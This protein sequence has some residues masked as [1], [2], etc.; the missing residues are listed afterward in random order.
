M[1]G[2]K[3]KD[4]NGVKQSQDGLIEGTFCSSTYKRSPVSESSAAPQTLA[5]PI[6]L[7]W[8]HHAGLL[9]FSGVIEA[10]GR[11][12][13]GDGELMRQLLGQLLVGAVNIEQS[14]L[15][16]HEDLSLLLGPSVSKDLGTQRRRLSHAATEANAVALLRF[17]GQLIGLEGQKDFYLDP[18]S[19]H[20]SGEK[21]IL[22]GWCPG[23]G[24]AD[25][26]LHSDFIHTATGEP[27]Y[28]QTTDNYQDL[29]ERVFTL[30]E[31]FRQHIYPHPNQSLTFVIDRAIFSAQT[32]E[33]FIEQSHLHLIS[34]EK[35]YQPGDWQEGLPADGQF[36]IQKTRNHRADIRTYHFA[37]QEQRWKN[38]P[39]MRRLLVRATNPKNKTVEVSVLTDDLERPAEEVITLIFNR[40]LQENDF[41]Y[42]DK[43]FGIDEIT[44]YKSVAYV[45]LAEQLETK[46]IK[47]A[48]YKALEKQRRQTTT[49][50]KTLLLK[51][52]QGKRR[53][54]HHEQELQRQQAAAQRSPSELSAPAAQVQK[55]ILANRQGQIKRLQSNL[56]RWD[57]QI[58]EQ[59]EQLEQIQSKLEQTEKET[60]RLKELIAQGAVKLQGS[61]K[62]LMDILKI[63]ARNAFYQALE[64]FRSAYDNL[65]DDHVL[66]R[67][68]THSSGLIEADPHSVR[69]SVLAQPDYAPY[70]RKLFEDYFAQLNQSEPLMPDGSN[71]RL[72]LFLTDKTGFELV[73]KTG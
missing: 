19:K 58:E 31:Q 63:I 27:A 18:H 48:H 71:R 45:Q 61:D 66:F 50:L 16:N 49:T 23:I 14:K 35:N 21:N 24:R 64:P 38:N 9:L 73:L 6:P 22:K 52:D 69:C 28:L 41:K 36:H 3:K 32:F 4:S 34:W 67:S 20:Y 51:H 55:K 29:R 46:Q 37:Y 17:N 62:K 53:K 44:S 72:Q 40:W 56:L 25:K 33:K 12:G 15:L 65:R 39:H 2:G 68:L 60:T 47:S 5:L 1:R 8:L 13:G 10:V 26:V 7:Q 11:Y 70:L 57:Q 43:H 30:I 59:Y 54:R 42:L